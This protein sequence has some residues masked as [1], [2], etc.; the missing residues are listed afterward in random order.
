MRWKARVHRFIAQSPS[1]L[2]EMERAIAQGQ[3]DAARIVAVLGKT[4]GNGCVNDFT[5][6]YATQTVNASLAAHAAATGQ[7]EQRAV[8]VMSGG[9]EGCLSPH[10]LVFEKLP[11]SD[12]AGIAHAKGGETR[13]AMAQTTTRALLPEEIGRTEHIQLVCDAVRQ[14]IQDAGITCA[15]DVH[16]VQVKCPLLTRQR[17][18]EARARGETTA[19]DDTYKSMACS[20]GASALGV[21]A[22][23]DEVGMTSLEELGA[24]VCSNYGLYSARASTSAGV[25]LMH[26]EILVLGNSAAWG[27]SLKIAHRVMA[28]AI[29]LGAVQGVLGDLGLDASRQLAAPASARLVALLAKAEPSRSGS[30]RGARHTMLDDSDIAATRHARALVGGVLAAVVGD[31]R[32]FV[33]GGAEH[34]GPD[35]GGPVA[36][37]ADVSGITL[38]VA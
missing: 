20:R 13:L 6:G 7:T 8:V 18:A 26:N 27:G 4:E 24:A 14:A 31:T 30:I 35:G 12:S 25:E 38:E 2:S 21:A 28:D 23:L 9:T 36:A 3:L 22:A 10:W 11:D 16:Y 1:D 32:L 15:A 29:D 5:R 19:T 17:I 34:Q 37:I 33:S